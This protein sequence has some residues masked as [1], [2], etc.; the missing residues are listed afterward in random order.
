[1]ETCPP[2][3]GS[4]R[5][6]SFSMAAADAAEKDKTG[7]CEDRESIIRSQLCGSVCGDVSLCRGCTRALRLANTIHVRGS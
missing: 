7:G 2:E 3:L 5:S 6:S 4:V 1:V